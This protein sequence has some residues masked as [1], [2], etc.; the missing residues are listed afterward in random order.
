MN[1]DSI[2]IVIQTLSSVVDDLELSVM[3]AYDQFLLKYGAGHVHV[4]RLESYFPA[5]DKQRLYIE[6][7]NECLVSMDLIRFNEIACKVRALAELVKNDAK[8]LL[9]YMSTG[10][11]SEFK[12]EQVH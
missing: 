4:T 6:E 9:L 5:I 2:K 12:E 11:H 3:Q 10:A 1:V 8:S 7:L